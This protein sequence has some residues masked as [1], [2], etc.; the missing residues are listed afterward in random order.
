[1]SKFD[2]IVIGGGIIGMATA[3]ELALQGVE[4]TLIEKN[5]LGMQSSWAA[6]GI[7]SSMRPW[8]ES[9]EA[10]L[11]SEYSKKSYPDFVNALQI[12]TGIDPEYIKS[13]LVIV[14]EG[15]TAKAKQ[16]ADNNS[17]NTQDNFEK[18]TGHISIPEHSVLLPD[19]AQVRPP[20]LLKALRKSLENL[21][22]SI[23]ENTKITAIE[24]KNNQFHSIELNDEKM[25]ADSLIITAGAWSNSL[26]VDINFQIETTP[27]R[28]QMLCVQ[29]VEQ[30]SDKIILDGGH[31][32]IPR[33]DG[34][35]LIGSTM[36]DVGFI[37]ETTTAG[38]EELLEWA[39]SMSP[40]LRQAKVVSHWS[41]LRPATSNGKPFIGRLAKNKNIYVNT[42]HFRKGILQAPASAQLLVD[43]IFEKS[44]FMDIENFS[45]EKANIESVLV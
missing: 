6:G 45:L 2:F 14:D 8:A 30:I 40:S 19:I 24:I 1:L 9:H 12:E 33:K 27:L 3:R 44:S 10:V 34:R 35:L 5:A 28:G 11:L 43:S 38:K 13:G 22:V 37:D 29:P 42:G 17:V 25:T 21:S 32:F 23:Y 31:Y 20:R 15:H 4:V 18:N 16:W 7:I 36:E 26:G 39:Y 41:G